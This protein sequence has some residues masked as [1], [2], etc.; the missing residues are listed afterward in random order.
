LGA[1]AR[2]TAPERKV[3]EF[4]KEYMVA[5]DQPI[6]EKSELKLD[7]LF[8]NMDVKNYITEEL[9]NKIIH[10][11]KSGVYGDLAGDNDYFTHT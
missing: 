7:Y 5:C 10:A 9:Y 4:Y 2:S 6:P 11:Y 3:L 1:H 8:C